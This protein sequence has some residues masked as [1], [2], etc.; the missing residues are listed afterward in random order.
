V[1]AF[2]YNVP[3]SN[4]IGSPT[5]NL[6]AG[7]EGE[8]PCLKYPP[9]IFYILAGGIQG[10]Q[11]DRQNFDHLEGQI[12]RWVLKVALETNLPPWPD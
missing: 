2:E 4:C 8:A 3:K 1:R 9:G 11:L 12:M 7:P 10:S 6:F 5:E